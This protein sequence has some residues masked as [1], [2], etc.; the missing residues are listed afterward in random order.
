MIELAP[1]A[2][3]KV[4][5]GR[6][7]LPLLAICPCG[8]KRTVP[9]RSLK[10]NDDDTTPLYGRPFKCKACGSHDVTLFAIETTAELL[11]LQQ[12][13]GR[14]EP[15]VPVRSHPTPSRQIAEPDE[16]FL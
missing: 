9:F 10:T 13:R 4:A 12:E 5:C 14:T 6:S 8:R 2:P 7:G 1:D 3:G 15:K 11:A 16:A